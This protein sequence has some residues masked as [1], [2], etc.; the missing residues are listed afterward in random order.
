MAGALL[1]L[2]CLRRKS[3][4][5]ACKLESRQSFDVRAGFVVA[6]LFQMGLFG[7]AIGKLVGLLVLNACKTA[8]FSASGIGSCRPPDFFRPDNAFFRKFVPL[9]S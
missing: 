4:F 9:L 5:G 7:G 8:V 2:I 3:H 1:R 6:R